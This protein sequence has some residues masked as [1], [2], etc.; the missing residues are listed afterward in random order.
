[1]FVDNVL[2]RLNDSLPPSERLNVEMLCEYSIQEY[3]SS[4]LTPVRMRQQQREAM[5][6][7]NASLPLMN[8]LAASSVDTYDPRRFLRE[9]VEPVQEHNIAPETILVTDSISSSSLRPVAA[10]D[11]CSSIL[12]G[13]PKDKVLIFDQF[14]ELLTYDAGTDEA[15][16][17]LFREL[18]AALSDKSCWV[19]FAI[20]EDYMASLDQYRDYIPDAFRAKFRLD[21]LATEQAIDAIEMPA[22]DKHVIFRR[23]ATEQLIKAL[24][25]NINRPPSS[26]VDPSQ[27]QVVCR[28]MWDAMPVN[29]NVIDVRDVPSVPQVNGALSQYYARTI[30]SLS[31]KYKYPERQLREWFDKAL[32]NPQGYR[33]QVTYGPTGGYEV[34]K[35]ALRELERLYLIR[36]DIRLDTAWYELA[37]ERLI[38]PIREDNKQWRIENYSE[39]Q[40]AAEE[41]DL[42]SRPSYKLLTGRALAVGKKWVK[43]NRHVSR[44]ETDFLLASQQ[45]A[46]TRLWRFISGVLIGIAISLLAMMWWRSRTATHEANLARA[47]ELSETALSSIVAKNP[48]PDRSILLALEGALFVYRETPLLP[49]D[50]TEALNAAL[51]ASRLRSLYKYE[52]N[53]ISVAFTPDDQY[54]AIKTES[55]ILEIFDWNTGERVRLKVE[56][57][58]TTGLSGETL[59]ISS[60]RAATVGDSGEIVVWEFERPFEVAATPLPRFNADVGTVTGLAMSSDGA[61]LIISGTRSVALFDITVRPPRLLA[62]KEL[63]GI[64]SVR[65]S[66]DN[67]V[68][69]CTTTKGVFVWNASQLTIPAKVLRDSAGVSVAAVSP[70]GEW[71]AA[72]SSKGLILWR[73]PAFTSSPEV[74]SASDFGGVS[75]LAFDRTGRHL[76]AGG[77]NGR[78]LVWTM[79]RTNALSAV[80]SKTASDAEV[81]VRRRE[82]E[83]VHNEIELAFELDGHADKINS[84][85]FSP[86]GKRIGTASK[87]RSVRIWSTETA[88]LPTDVR[89][90]LSSDGSVIVQVAR[91]T[92]RLWDIHTRRV[93]FTVQCSPCISAAIS[94][95]NRRMMT[96][97]NEG[98]SI[99][100]VINRTFM[101]TVPKTKYSWAAALNRDGSRIA[102]IGVNG[103]HVWDASSRTFI[104]DGDSLEGQLEAVAMN[105][106]GDY[107]AA[108]GDNGSV[109]VVHLTR[110]GSDAVRSIAVSA[111]VV[112]LAISST[113]SPILA[114]AQTDGTLVVLSLLDGRE[115]HRSSVSVK[116]HKITSLSIS[117]DGHFVAASSH[118]GATVIPLGEAEPFKASSKPIESL[119]FGEDSSSLAVLSE[120]AEIDTFVLSPDSLIALGRSRV[121]RPMSEDECGHYLHMHSCPDSMHNL[122]V[123]IEAEAASKANDLDKGRSLFETANL[124]DHSLA[125][126]PAQSARDLRASA[127]I[128][129]A[130]YILSAAQDSSVDSADRDRMVAA[131]VSSF[132]EAKQRHHADAGL[133]YRLALETLE[134]GEGIAKFGDIPAAIKL[135]RMGKALDPKALISN[136]S[137][138]AATLLNNL[139]WYGT[140]WNY[141]K[142]VAQFCEDGVEQAPRTANF[143]DSRG[144]QRACIGDLSGAMA[145]FRDFIDSNEPSEA[146]KERRRDWISKL[147]RGNNI[148]TSGVLASLR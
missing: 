50:V 27:L 141:A 9:V 24:K 67:K 103:L 14:E 48:D 145:D 59:A 127:L 42:A 88:S 29:T 140:I 35:T 60:R 68:A 30:R 148:C 78:V 17:D 77:E 15:R 117:P 112:K 138:N 87:D 133:D 90:Q 101:Y 66:P 21:L 105:A 4:I 106:S 47:H 38:L 122:G 95:D 28:S 94:S 135:Y 125:V 123:Y 108:G 16:E 41:W 1:M 55:G 52:E 19:L 34:D 44:I 118:D 146:D 2:C 61:R 6:E 26:H 126:D 129:K 3:L 36:S 23:D 18:G 91:E 81:V 104:Y 32:V 144:L 5:H 53:A 8:R 120:T 142:D 83:P 11:S 51:N 7:F 121:T 143:R 58:Q 13:R 89:G 114:I 115:I 76:A 86:D 84:L 139:C 39:F 80:S 116:A 70:D 99:W 128:Q 96:S 85:A 82:Q 109:Q 22:A 45:S 147:S 33:A 111:P 132:S 119:A 79:P 110:T 134:A 31:E 113:F 75:A 64:L 73:G 93:P 97:D 102:A 130:E 40:R 56:P 107:V 49:G 100:N 136:T 63:D 20:R 37:H 54:V 46:G 92:A 137:Q 131:V 124:A 57:K 12:E 62:H 98:L 72:G 69:V 25:T 74:V 10:L 71:I 43:E 65:L